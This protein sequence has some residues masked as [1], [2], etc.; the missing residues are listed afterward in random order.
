MVY[1]WP[2]DGR[3]GLRMEK[4]VYRW[5]R[6]FTNGRYGSLMVEV[7][8]IWEKRLKKEHVIIFLRGGL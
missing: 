3:D 6:F 2:T 4:M 8:V 5:K 7:V 1:K